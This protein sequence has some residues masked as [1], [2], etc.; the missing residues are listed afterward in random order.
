MSNKSCFLI[1]FNTHTHIYVCVC[2]LSGFS[3]VRL[4]A[5]PWTVARQAPLFMR[6]SRLDYWSGLPCPL[7]RDLP[8][9]GIKPTSLMS[10]ALAAASATC[11]LIYIYTCLHTH[12]CVYMCMCIDLYTHIVQYWRRQWQPTP[13]LLP[14]KS[15]GRRSLVGFSP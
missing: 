7:P 1:Y 13:V 10:P 15:H 9:P 3:H 11:L 12:T 5:T 2:M 4:F 6:F 14:R 8:D